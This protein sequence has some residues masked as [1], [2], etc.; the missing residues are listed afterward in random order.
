ME[1]LSNIFPSSF[2]KNQK[3]KDQPQN[4]ITNELACKKGYNFEQRDF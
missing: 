2:K 1:T 4:Q 3:T